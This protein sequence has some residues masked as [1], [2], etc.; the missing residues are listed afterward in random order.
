MIEVLHNDIYYQPVSSHKHQLEIDTD[1][2]GEKIKF[3]KSD[4]VGL[5]TT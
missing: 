1:R 2:S 3:L 4:I 5:Q